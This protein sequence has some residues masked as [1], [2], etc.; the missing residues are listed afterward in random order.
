MIL[1]KGLRSSSIPSFYVSYISKKNKNY[2]SCGYEKYGN[3]RVIM[4]MKNFG[5]WLDGYPAISVD[6]NNNTTYSIAIVNPYNISN[7]FTLEIN[8]LG[9]KKSFRVLAQSVRQINLCNIIKEK[10][11]TGQF[12]TYGKNRLITFVINH[13]SE[14]ISQITTVEHSDPFRAEL[15]YQPRLQFFRNLVHK[16][17]KYIRS[18]FNN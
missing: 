2:I 10:L 7:S 13:N 5:M 11:W 9:I 3:P 12:Y 16:K 14:K 17:I 6:I 8:S 15:S 18:I 4:Q 1:G